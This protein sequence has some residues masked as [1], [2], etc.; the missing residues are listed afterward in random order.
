MS[1]TVNSALDLKTIFVERLL[2]KGGRAVDATMGN[3][4]DLLQ[5]SN[6]VGSEGFVWGFDIQDAALSATRALLETRAA[7]QNYRLVK[8]CHSRVSEHVDAPIDLFLYN[9]GYLPGGGD[10]RI[11]TE[12]PTTLSSMKAAMGLLSDTGSLLIVSYPGHATGFVEAQAVSAFCEQLDQ[13]GWNVL[14]CVFPNQ[15]NHPPV[16][17]LVQKRGTP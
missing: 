3:G 15:A 13:R 1:L 11:T 7:H 9:L 14:R 6:Q 17:H 5:L 10:R 16:F 12:A 2:P 8:S 4:H